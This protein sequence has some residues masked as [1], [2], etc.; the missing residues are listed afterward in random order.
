MLIEGSKL[1]KY[2]ILSLHTAS[3]IAEVKGLVIDPNF[4]KVVAFEISAASSRQSLFLEASSVREFS[5]MGM[6]V[7]S[8]EEFVEKDDVIKLKETIDLG[9]SLDNM[10]VISKKKAMLGRIE[11]FIINTED[12]QIMQLIVKRPIYK[13][14]ID[15]ELVIGRSDIHEINDSEIIVKSEEG[16]IMKKSGTLDFVPNFVNPFKDGKYIARGNEN[17]VSE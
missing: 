14:L 7:D 16:T 11:D 3:R 13:A 4:L 5:K 6:I 15:P 2:P 12:F 8:D 9:F 17:S 10:K 1:L